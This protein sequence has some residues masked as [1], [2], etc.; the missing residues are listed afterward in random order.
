MQKTINHQDHAASLSDL[1]A[2]TGRL[3]SVR[4]EE[5]SR[6]ARQIH[7]ELGQALTALKMDLAWLQDRLAR[8][9]HRP[10]IAPLL[11]KARSMSELID[12][13]VQRV[14][15]IATELRPGVLD[16]LG[17]AAAVEWQAQDFENHSGIRCL[18]VANPEDLELDRDRSTAAFRILQEALTNVARHAGA[19]EVSISLQKDA[20]TVILEVSDD[21]RGI[22]DQDSKRVCSLGIL[23]MRERAALVGGQ[24][25]VIRLGER[26]TRV[27]L[28]MPCA[29]IR[30]QE[31][32]VRKSEVRKK[33]E[34]QPV[35]SLTSDQ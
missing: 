11:D 31:P 28:R 26:G 32:E 7:D 5:R 22:G 3:Q 14:R 34:E 6:I 16:N 8:V 30:G 13:T 19:S 23:G 1:R 10:W 27:T 25:E 33:S 2:L 15:R 4:E 18:V 12:A 24:L 35:F 9:S 21:G 17:L 20:A 29:V